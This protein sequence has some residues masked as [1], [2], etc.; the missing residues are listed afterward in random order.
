M[1]TTLEAVET[2]TH[3]SFE[4]LALHAGTTADPVTGAMLTP[5]YQTTT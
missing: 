5:I 1:I 4:T 3:Y 2:D